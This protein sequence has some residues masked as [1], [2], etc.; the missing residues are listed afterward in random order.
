[1]FAFYVPMRLRWN[2]YAAK[3]DQDIDAGWVVMSLLQMHAG[4]MIP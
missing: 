4:F 2:T 3:V 1:M